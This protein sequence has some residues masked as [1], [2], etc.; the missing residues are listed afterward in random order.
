MVY[1]TT[2]RAFARSIFNDIVEFRYESFFEHE[3]DWMLWA[4]ENLYVERA[5]DRLLKI[6][7]DI[8]T[9]KKQITE[10]YPYVICCHHN[11]NRNNDHTTMEKDWQTALEQAVKSFHKIPH[12]RLTIYDVKNDKRYTHEEIIAIIKD[13]YVV[14]YIN[15]S[16]GGNVTDSYFTV[17]DDAINAGDAWLHDVEHSHK[18]GFS[19][20]R[21][22]ETNYE[23]ISL[24]NGH[25]VSITKYSME[26]KL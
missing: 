8:M 11:H 15:G 23:Y 17:L 5:N 12:S 25:S 18:D 1:R 9:I 4:L 16:G 20:E 26:K 19:K 7:D 13:Y 21:I 22:E 3:S 10:H 14:R 6:F 2:D 24:D